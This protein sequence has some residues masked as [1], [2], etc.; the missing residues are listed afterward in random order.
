MLN[1]LVVVAGQVA[2]LFLLMGVGFVLAKGGWLSDKS[3]SQLT[4]LLFYCV[5][6]CIVISRLQI[7][8]DITFLVS[9]GE[10]FLAMAAYYVIFLSVGQLLFR[11]QPR[12]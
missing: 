2:T 8:E 5:S 3:V 11:K 6:P 9:L 12:P 1:D 4:H 7:D 10:V